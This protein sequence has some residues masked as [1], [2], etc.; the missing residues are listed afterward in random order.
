MWWNIIVA[1]LI[2]IAVE[3][4][5]LMLLAWLMEKLFNKLFPCMIFVPENEIR[6]HEAGHLL[7]FIKQASNNQNNSKN[8]HLSSGFV[9]CCSSKKCGYVEVKGRFQGN[10]MID[11]AGIAAVHRFNNKKLTRFGLFVEKWFRGGYSDITKA[12]NRMEN[13]RRVVYLTNVLIDGYTERDIEFI[14]KIVDMLAQK[15][16][17]T[18]RKFKHLS[19]FLSKSEMYKLSREYYKLSNAS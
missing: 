1:G 18:Y 4:P 13:S 16:Y 5:L 12:Y 6:I 9:M 15:P 10:A 17:T 2:I 19:Q 7:E 11:M 8:R 14:K 3:F